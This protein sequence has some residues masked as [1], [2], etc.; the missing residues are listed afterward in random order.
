MEKTFTGEDVYS[1]IQ[2]SDT[3]MAYG[4]TTRMKGQYFHLFT[5]AGLRG[6]CPEQFYR[7]FTQG[8][9]AQVTITSTSY[10]RKDAA[11]GQEV[12]AEGLSLGYITYDRLINLQGQMGNL[13]VAKVKKQISVKRASAVAIAELGLKREDMAM[14]DELLKEA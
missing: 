13:E 5:H 12:D 8:K 9:V 11:T 2:V 10:K 4:E 1:A 3:K 14:V 7:D 6:T